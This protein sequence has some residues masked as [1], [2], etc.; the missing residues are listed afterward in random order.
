MTTPPPDSSGPE[1]H[2]SIMREIGQLSTECERRHGR[3]G[4]AIGGC[5]TRIDMNQ[6]QLADHRDRLIELMGRSGGEGKVGMLEKDLAEVK[7]D[8][9]KTNEA[10]TANT[11]EITRM[12]LTQFSWG[13]GGAGVGGGLVYAIAEGIRYIF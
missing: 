1:I 4:Q 8:Q 11:N 10:V 12:K 2:P 13:A 3:N 9:E 7:E 5:H 6:E